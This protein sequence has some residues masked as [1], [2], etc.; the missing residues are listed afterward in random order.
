[1]NVETVKMSS[2]GQIV[3]PQNIRDKLELKDGEKFVVVGEDDTIVL[4]KIQPPSGLAELLKKT[5]AFAKEKG[6]TTKD[7]E[8]A[9]RKTRK[10]SGN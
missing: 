10:S 7:V 5:R 2:R 3:I 4:R 1:M 8:E 9:I 6:I